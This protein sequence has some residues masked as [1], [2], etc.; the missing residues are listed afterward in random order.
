MFRED[1]SIWSRM[2]RSTQD[3]H[4]YCPTS[5]YGDGYTRSVCRVISEY[6]ASTVP[7]FPQVK[8]ENKSIMVLSELYGQVMLDLKLVM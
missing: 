8:L 7:L 6:F 5:Y 4:I 1:I 2:S 3:R